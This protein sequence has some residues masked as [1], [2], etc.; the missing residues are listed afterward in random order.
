MKL[1][2]LKFTLSDGSTRDIDVN[3]VEPLPKPEFV[4]AMDRGAP[5]RSNGTDR[6][7]LPEFG[8]LLLS[9]V[10]RPEFREGLLGCLG[11]QHLRDIER[12]GDRRAKIVLWCDIVKAIAGQ[13][14]LRLAGLL[15]LFAVADKIRR[16]L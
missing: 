11:E 7:T 3:K 14:W 13:V 1:E 12:L 4:A 6:Q 15:G 16:W 9:L 10:T 5:T 8:A 2:T